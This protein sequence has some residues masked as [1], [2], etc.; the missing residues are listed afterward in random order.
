MCLLSE[1][2]DNQPTVLLL[3]FATDLIDS[4][5]G[6]HIFRICFQKK[7][8]N[9]DSNRKCREEML[10]N[11][12][13]IVAKAVLH[14]SSRCSSAVPRCS[15]PSC[16]VAPARLASA[17][18]W[19]QHVGGLGVRN[20]VWLHRWHGN[21]DIASTGKVREGNGEEDATVLPLCIYLQIYGPQHTHTH[22]HLL[23]RAVKS[24]FTQY[25][26]LS[27]GKNNSSDL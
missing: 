16:N 14:H 20:R 8:K 17:L 23:D 27:G 12:T 9:K 6:I 19:T 13:L 26:Q 2:K 1:L 4:K 10:N 25:T 15:S 18:L 21:K 5:N 3:I 22:T 11:L 24:T 7:K